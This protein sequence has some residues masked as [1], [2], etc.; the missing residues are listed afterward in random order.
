VGEGFSLN[1]NS[2]VVHEGRKGSPFLET[3]QARGPIY[4]KLGKAGQKLGG[5]VGGEGSS[6]GTSSPLQ[7]TAFY[8][9]KTSEFYLLVRGIAGDLYPDDSAGPV[10][11]VRSGFRRGVLLPCQK[12][13]MAWPC[14]TIK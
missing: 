8:G 9:K 7:T 3:A 12:R 2:R 11:L 6:E 10:V 1:G 14:R 4:L 13:K 5:D